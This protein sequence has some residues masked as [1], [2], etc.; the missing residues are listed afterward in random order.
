[1]RRRRMRLFFFGQMRLQL[2]LKPQPPLE[3]GA[4]TLGILV[5]V[6]PNGLNRDG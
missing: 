5:A 4:E 1:M 2:I 6:H 3:Q